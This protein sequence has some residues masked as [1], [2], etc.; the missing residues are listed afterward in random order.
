[1]GLLQSLKRFGTKVRQT[2]SHR[3]LYSDTTACAGSSRSSCWSLLEDLHPV[4]MLSEFSQPRDE[5]S[6]VTAEEARGLLS[7]DGSDNGEEAC[8]VVQQPI[9]GSVIYR[10]AACPLLGWRLST[11][12][13]L[14]NLKRSSDVIRL[15]HTK[16]IPAW[17][18]SSN[19]D[20]QQMILSVI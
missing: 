9:V 3:T 6:H 10:L 1:M 2:F 17:T 7:H 15:A 14:L 13:C 18:L 16:M 12:N 4:D 5:D 11:R 19:S 20:Q 8:D